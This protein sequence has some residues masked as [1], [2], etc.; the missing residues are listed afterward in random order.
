[1]RILIILAFFMSNISFAADESL[2]DEYIQYGIEFNNAKNT[3]SKTALACVYE[4]IFNTMDEQDKEYFRKI[5]AYKKENPR[6]SAKKVATETKALYDPSGKLEK[7]INKK[8]KLAR[9]QFMEKC[10]K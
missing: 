9:P 5:L 2:L 7:S 6:L 8:V 4:T 10:Y 1:M 3:T